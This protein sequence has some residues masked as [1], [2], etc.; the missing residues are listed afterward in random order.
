MGR[1]ITVNNKMQKGYTYETT[2]EK[3]RED[4]KPQLSPK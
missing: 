2:N 3:F 4:F 1:K